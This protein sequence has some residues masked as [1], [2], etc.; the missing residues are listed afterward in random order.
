MFFIFDNV[1]VFQVVQQITAVCVGLLFV[2]GQSQKAP[3][4]LLTL[5]LALS[6]VTRDEPH[7]TWG[8]FLQAGVMKNPVCSSQNEEKSM[9]NVRVPDNLT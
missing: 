5:Q 2:P 7:V 9:L 1:I 4:T 6:L 3:F 8:S